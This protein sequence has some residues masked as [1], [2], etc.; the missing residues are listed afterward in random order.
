MVQDA[1]EGMPQPAVLRLHTSDGQVLVTWGRSVLYRYDADD[2]GMRNLAIVALTAVTIFL[3]LDIRTV[4]DM[5]K[6]PDALPV[7]TL[8]QVPLTCRERLIDSTDG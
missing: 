4:G 6:L 5:G 2:T 8:P 1:L 7:L 3:G